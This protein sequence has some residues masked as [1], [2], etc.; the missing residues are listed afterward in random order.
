MRCR[1]CGLELDERD[2]KRNGAYQ[3]PECGTIHHTAISSR[4]SPSPWRRKRRVRFAANDNVFTRKF[5]LLPLWGWIGIAVLVIAIALILLLPLG[6]KDA[7]APSNPDMPAATDE[8]IIET[9]PD[10]S[11]EEI[12]PDGDITSN[13]GAAPAAPAT[14]GHTGIGVNDFIVSFDWAMSYLKYSASLQL[15]SEQTSSSG[16]LIQTYSYE[17]WYQLTLTVDPSTNQIRSAAATV[18]ED[19]SGANAA[20]MRNAFISMLYGFDTTLNATKAGSEVDGMMA[21]SV[22][23]YGTSSMVARITHDG[24]SGYTME[25]SGK[26]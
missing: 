19:E 24:S 23:T 1:A 7:K 12:N 21:D 5:W 11:T 14:S 2:L 18:P 26:L 8:P 17:D 22:R 9:S 6:G 4:V 3:C 16:E 10:I 20:R 25:I 13:V 15:T